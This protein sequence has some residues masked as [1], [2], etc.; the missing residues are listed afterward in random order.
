MDTAQLRQQPVVWS[1]SLQLSQSRARSHACG[2]WLSADAIPAV[3]RLG[4]LGVNVQRVAELSSLDA[5]TYQASEANDAVALQR[6]SFEAPPGSYYVSM[7]QPLAYL[8]AAALEPDTPYS[9]YSAGVL[10]D[11]SKVARVVALPQIVFDED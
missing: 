8:A 3:E 6:N 4:M 9:F 7:N 2:Y 11:L 5:E 10:K 1:D